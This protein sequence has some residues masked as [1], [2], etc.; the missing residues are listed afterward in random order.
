MT[1]SAT[2]GTPSTNPLVSSIGQ[3]RQVAMR[4]G[5]AA[6][7]VA[8]AVD[9][10]MG[11]PAER[12]VWTTEHWFTGGILPWLSVWAIPVATV[13]PYCATACTTS[14]GCCSAG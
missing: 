7:N 9:P 11:L 10:P 2:R 5:H 1:I 8:D 3:N 12:H 14:T 4:W 6:R 13:W